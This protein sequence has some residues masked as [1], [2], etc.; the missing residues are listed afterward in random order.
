MKMSTYFLNFSL[1]LIF[2]FAKYASRHPYFICR[3]DSDSKYFRL[4]RT[5]FSPK[6]S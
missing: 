2:L 4:S 6:L 3:S 1:S 5:T